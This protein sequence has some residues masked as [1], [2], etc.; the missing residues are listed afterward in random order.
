MG[1]LP[2][3]FLFNSAASQRAAT[4]IASGAEAATGEPLYTNVPTPGKEVS[5]EPAIEPPATT[6]ARA[7]MKLRVRILTV[8]GFRTP[9]PSAVFVGRC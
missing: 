6:K 7:S 1:A 4:K 5:D 9:A 3:I 8:S 2:T